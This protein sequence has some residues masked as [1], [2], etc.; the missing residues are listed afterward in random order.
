[1]GHLELFYFYSLNKWTFTDYFIND[2]YNNG[3]ITHKPNLNENITAERKTGRQEEEG[4][5]GLGILFTS[6][7]KKKMGLLTCI[8]PTLPFSSLERVRFLN[9]FEKSLLYVHHICFYLTENPVI[10]CM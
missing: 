7:T 2:M 3:Q 1:M 9:V 10:F 6:L 8:H 5:G 4:G